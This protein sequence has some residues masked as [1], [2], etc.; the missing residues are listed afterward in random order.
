MRS[1]PQCCTRKSVRHSTFF[2]IRTKRQ[3]ITVKTEQ[4]FTVTNLSLGGWEGL[5]P[6]FLTRTQLSLFLLQDFK[7]NK[8][9]N[10]PIGVHVV[11]PFFSPV[12]LGRVPI[13]F[14]TFRNTTKK[15]WKFDFCEMVLLRQ[16]W[17][18]LKMCNW[19]K[20]R[21]KRKKTEI[22]LTLSN[23]LWMIAYSQV[24]AH[25]CLTRELLPAVF[26][27]WAGSLLFNQPGELRLLC[28]HHI[29]AKLSADTRST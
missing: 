15:F 3:I 10:K 6:L 5:A 26:P 12:Y 24:L 19:K 29:D 21:K 9:P 27:P 13:R 28:V 25:Y 7:A 8:Y 2:W 1:P 23:E 20:K 22:S 4:G 18:S 11:Y 17:K 14:I 16:I